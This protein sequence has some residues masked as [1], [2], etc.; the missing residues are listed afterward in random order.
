MINGIGGTSGPDLSHVGSKRD[1]EWL[2]EHFEDP[3]KV[4]PNSAMPKVEAPEADIEQLTN[5]MLTL[6]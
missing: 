1:R 6:K 3:Q 5:Y 2:N 4:V